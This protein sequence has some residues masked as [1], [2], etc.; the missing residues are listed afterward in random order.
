MLSS[1]DIPDPTEMLGTVIEGLQV[2]IYAA[3][4]RNTEECAGLGEVTSGLRDHQ[5][6][7]LDK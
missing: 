3:A 2:S 4:E 7:P 6:S 1:L 5:L